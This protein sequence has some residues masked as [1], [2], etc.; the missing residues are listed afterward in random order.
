MGFGPVVWIFF[1]RYG[2]IFR[3]FFLFLAGFDAR[4]PLNLPLIRPL[5]AY[6]AV[7]ELFGAY[8]LHHYI[9]YAPPGKNTI[10]FCYIWPYRRRI[11]GFFAAK[12]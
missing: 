1:P 4:L 12:L 11:I 6:L 2:A 10:K 7:F 5:G 8:I 3:V 9:I